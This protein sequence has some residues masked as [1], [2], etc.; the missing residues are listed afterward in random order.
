METTFHVPMWLLSNVGG[1]VGLVVGFGILSLTLKNI[2]KS[3]VTQGKRSR[4]R[5]EQKQQREMK[6]EGEA[7]QAKRD[8]KLEKDI[9]KQ[10]K[11]SRILPGP[12]RKLYDFL[13]NEKTATR[14]TVLMIAFTFER[15]V[16][17]PLHVVPDLSPSG[18]EAILSQSYF[19]QPAGDDH[20]NCHLEITGLFDDYI[21]F[22]EEV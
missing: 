1:F 4:E 18:L 22:P 13:H 17:K 3:I 20:R 6:L 21:K 10:A 11:L 9:A 16:L 19:N 12:W 7:A 8:K 14:E 15:D 2:R 5:K